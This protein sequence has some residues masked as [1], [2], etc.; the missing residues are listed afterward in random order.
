[1]TKLELMG[2]QKA[3]GQTMVTIRAIGSETLRVTMAAGVDNAISNMAV[4]LA[5]E[6]IEGGFDRQEF[7][8]GCYA[9]VTQ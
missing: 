8:R 7:L 5:G 6:T 4:M 3:F 2:I 9:P 1:M